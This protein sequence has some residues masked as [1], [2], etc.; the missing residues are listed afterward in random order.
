MITAVTVIPLSVMNNLLLL[1]LIFILLFSKISLEILMYN[2]NNRYFRGR[3]PKQLP[4]YTFIVERYLL[5][6]K[7]IRWEGLKLVDVEK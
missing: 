7:I 4:S 5:R 2:Q 6:F 1:L 3:G